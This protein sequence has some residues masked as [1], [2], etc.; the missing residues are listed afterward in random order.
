MLTIIHEKAKRMVDGDSIQRE[1]QQEV[2]RK[3]K[4]KK[5]LRTEGT[6]DS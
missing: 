2:K 5:V 6:D 3:D 1:K 4:K